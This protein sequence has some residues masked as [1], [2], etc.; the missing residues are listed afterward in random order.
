MNDTTGTLTIRNISK[1]THVC[2]LP[3]PQVLCPRRSFQCK[4]LN[5]IA[6]DKQCDKIVD[7][8]Q[9]EDEEECEDKNCSH[10]DDEEDCGD[11]NPP[12][13]EDDG[14]F[15][16]RSGSHLEAKDDDRR[17]SHGKNE[18]GFG[19]RRQNT[20]DVNCQTDCAW[21]HCTCSAQYFQCDGGGC[22]PAGV[23]CDHQKNCADGSDELYCG[24]L[25]C[26]A[27]QLPC[28]DGKMCV[29]AAT[30]FDGVENCADASDEVFHPGEA[31]LGIQCRDNTCIPVGWL[32]D[33]IADCTE[34]EDET[35]SILQRAIGTQQEWSCT[36]TML[37]CRGGVNKCYP[38]KQHCVYDT[39]SKGNLYACR[40]AM[41]LSDCTSFD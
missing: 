25:L 12:K 38:Q 26:S 36:N 16:K 30:W 37:A 18:K 2:L 10:G 20:T 33:G 31:C 24:N 15:K 19:D 21:P 40:N 5:C 14:S 8:S 35:D 17:C 4:D 28:N 41:H 13:K 23:I 7:C 11:I 1:S 34:D 6:A 22:V 32:N 39:D 27:G 3:I 9:G 29:D